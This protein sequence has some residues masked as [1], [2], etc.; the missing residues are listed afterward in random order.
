[1][2]L[3]NCKECNKEIS[4]LAISCPNCGAPVKKHNE[5]IYSE[6]YEN[7]KEN[8]LEQ[9]EKMPKQRKANL[10]IGGI[11]L[12]FCCKLLLS[13]PYEMI[14]YFI[15]IIL[16]FGFVTIINYKTSSS[17]N[18]SGNYL[19]MAFAL[20]L[21]I[22]YTYYHKGFF[23]VYGFI[24]IETLAENTRIAS[25]LYI[26]VLPCIISYIALFIKKWTVNKTLQISL[27]IYNVIILIFCIV[28]L[29][30]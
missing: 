18:Y 3:I 15:P 8:A 14:D 25:S 11:L 13:P 7:P 27:I 16:L 30:N 17:A 6:N 29:Y 20:L 12:V 24:S 4:N 19:L 22:V 1:M 23:S 10:V 9:K 5:T 21:N 26:A 28:E 2:A